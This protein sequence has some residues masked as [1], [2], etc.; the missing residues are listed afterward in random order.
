MLHVR[1]D[2]LRPETPWAPREGYERF[3]HDPPPMNADSESKPLLPIITAST[4]S[5]RKGRFFSTY[6]EEEAGTFSPPE[7]QEKAAT[8]ML[9]ELVRWA[10]ALRTLRNGSA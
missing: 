7:V 6:I 1:W 4:R 3:T 2:G 5:G 10:G 9:D 8:V